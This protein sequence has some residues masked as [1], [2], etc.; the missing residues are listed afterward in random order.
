MAGV[1]ADIGIQQASTQ[2]SEDYA[3]TTKLINDVTDGTVAEGAVIGDVTLTAG[4]DIGDPGIML[5]V[6]AGVSNIQ[7]K[8]GFLADAAQ[9]PTAL[10][11]GVSQKIQ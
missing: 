4:D 2:I 8:D 1:G 5:A 9:K 7:V 6:S 11:K 3:A 10:S